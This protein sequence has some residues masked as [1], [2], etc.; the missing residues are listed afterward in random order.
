ML[1]F[2][3]CYFYVFLSSLAWSDDKY[4]DPRKNDEW[5]AKT[6]KILYVCQG[7][8]MLA[9]RCSDPAFRQVNVN[10]L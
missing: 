2:I 3:I 6:L 9:M 5:W 1:M 4:Y 7:Y 10:Y 8:F